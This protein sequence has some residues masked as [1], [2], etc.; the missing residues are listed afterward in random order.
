MIFTKISE[1][2]VWAAENTENGRAHS[3]WVGHCSLVERGELVIFDVIQLGLTAI[4]YRRRRFPGHKDS[5][6][7]DG[8]TYELKHCAFVGGLP[9]ACM[10]IEIPHWEIY[11]ILSQRFRLVKWEE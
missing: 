1:F 3:R 9:S 11:K 5:R 10:I 7:P 4:V 2:D 8:F 6:Q